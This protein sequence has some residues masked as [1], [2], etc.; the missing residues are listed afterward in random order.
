MQHYIRSNL[1]V[2]SES[3]RARIGELC[4]LP[5]PVASDL[6]DTTFDDARTVAGFEEKFSK[7]GELVIDWLTGRGDRRNGVWYQAAPFD[8]ASWPGMRRK[9]ISIVNEH[10]LG[11]RLEEA[12]GR[13]L[14]T[15]HAALL[16]EL[17]EDSQTKQRVVALALS[18][19]DAAWRFRTDQDARRRL[20]LQVVWH[21]WWRNTLSR[22]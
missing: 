11:A 9:I 17:P 14:S 21:R 3:L 4:R 15:L 8:S 5:T 2:M 12:G 16:G 7:Y 1:I 6:I 22:V 19:R 18:D 10:L 13:V 20:A